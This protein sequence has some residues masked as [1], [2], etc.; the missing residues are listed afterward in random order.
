MIQHGIKQ[1]PD[2]IH[3]GNLRKSHQILLAP[4]FRRSRPLLLELAQVV[5]VVNIVPVL[6]QSRGLAGGRNPH[7]GNAED[8]QVGDHGF[9]TGPVLAAIDGEIPFETLEDG[10][11][12]WAR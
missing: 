1:H 9:Q 7:A 10:F 5:Q 6:L 4:P 12:L 11:V 8:G 2:A 3:T